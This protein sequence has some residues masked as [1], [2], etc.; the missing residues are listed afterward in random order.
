MSKNSL[1]NAKLLCV[2]LISCLV[3]PCG[4]AKKN[5]QAKKDII[6]YVNKDPIY[7]SDL[8]REIALRAKLDPSFKLTPDTEREQLDLIINRK[9]IVQA[10]MEKGLSRQERFINT[11]RSFWEQTLIRDFIDFKK[12]E[13]QEYIFVTDDDVK[14]YYNDLSQKVTF[15]VL[16]ARDKRAIEEAHKKYLK[17]KD[18]SKW[19]VV[20]PVGYEDVSSGVLAGAFEMNKGEVKKLEDL[21]SH[22][23]VEMAEKEKVE[24]EPLESLRPEIEKRVFAM[25]ESRLLEDWLLEKR[26]RSRIKINKDFHQ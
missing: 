22:Y 13:L 8:K 12:K 7:E 17:D 5:A 10:A 18:T 19:Q 1:K 4:C 24:I 11:I 14:K 25:K 6:A 15:K 26:N 16:K 2:I 3:F 23:L 20:G 9:L 21:P